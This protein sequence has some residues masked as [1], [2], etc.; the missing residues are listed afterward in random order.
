ML[1]ICFIAQGFVISLP[2]IL[3]MEL[4]WRLWDVR[5]G[6]ARRGLSIPDPGVAVAELT[7]LRQPF[8]PVLREANGFR[9]S[10]YSWYALSSFGR[11]CATTQELSLRETARS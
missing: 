3:I 7:L 4:R 5:S 1:Q 10:R 2:R 8:R 11:F 9:G 6:P